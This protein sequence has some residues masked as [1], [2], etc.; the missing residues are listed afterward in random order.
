VPWIEADLREAIALASRMIE[1]VL[2]LGRIPQ[3]WMGLILGWES[4]T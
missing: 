2:V 1:R 3:N 4:L